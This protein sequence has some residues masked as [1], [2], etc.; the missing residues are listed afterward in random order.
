MGL[1]QLSLNDQLG[2]H[3]S[4]FF[5]SGNLIRPE[6]EMKKLVELRN[7]LPKKL[8]NRTKVEYDIWYDMGDNKRVHGYSYTDVLQKFLMI[9]V[10][11]NSMAR[12]LV[13]DCIKE[14]KTNEFGQKIIDDIIDNNKDKYKLKKYRG[15]GE[16][17]VI[18]LPGTNCYS[19]LVDEEKCKNLI[20]EHGAKLKLHPLSADSFRVHLK[21]VYGEQNLIHHKLS[22]HQVLEDCETVGCCY[23]SEMGLTGILKD[24]NFVFVG[25]DKNEMTTYQHIYS[26]LF[27]TNELGHYGEN[28][29]YRNRLVWFLSSQRNG[30]IHVDD[31]DAKEK[32]KSFFNNYR[33]IPHVAPKNFSS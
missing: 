22:G 25:K 27:D 6:E 14:K 17:F 9:R 32:I 29:T 33:D 5:K 4:H 16:K 24:K 12:Q 2:E 30:M 19:K 7:L 10:C 11:S 31:P 1:V 8:P 23:N 20:N 26:G 21:S 18:F 28:D 3:S 13:L 15:S